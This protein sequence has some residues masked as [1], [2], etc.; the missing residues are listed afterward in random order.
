[1]AEAFMARDDHHK[2][3]GLRNKVAVALREAIKKG[4]YP[5][6]SPLGRS[7]TRERFG[8]SRGP[9]REALIQRRRS[10]WSDPIPIAGALWRN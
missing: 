4:V 1:M 2:I 8:V 5:P 6:G 10:A 3:P 9:V 7:R